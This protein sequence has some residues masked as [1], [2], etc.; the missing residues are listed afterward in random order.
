M[1]KIAQVDTQADG[2]VCIP[3]NAAEQIEICYE[4]G[5]TDGLPVIPAT[6]ALADDML[7]A[8]KLP[9]EAVIAQM[10]SRK[11]AVTADKVAINAVLA[12]C[13]PEYMPVVVAAV[14][15]LATPEFG[16]HHVAAALAGPTIATVGGSTVTPPT[17]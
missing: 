14:K 11:A 13:R 10:P 6:R 12:G 1:E 17:A 8:C 5:W 4:R 15:A 3:I 16:L 7:E 9:P 2:E